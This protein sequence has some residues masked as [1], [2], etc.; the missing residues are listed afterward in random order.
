MG[1]YREQGSQIDE[2][3]QNGARAIFLNLPLGEYTL[4]GS[5]QPVTVENANP[6]FLS[7]AT[8]H[9]LVEGFEPF[10]FRFWFDPA[11]DCLTPLGFGRLKGDGWNPVLLTQ[12]SMAVAERPC[13][14]GQVIVC[15]AFLA[16]RVTANPTARLFATR[17]LKER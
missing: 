14:K 17:L 13:G 8:G 4:P 2:A 5:E 11:N 10:D 15:Q 9:P 3:I 1:L 6:H 7:R 16:D 12:G